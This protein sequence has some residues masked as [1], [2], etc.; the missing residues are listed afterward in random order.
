M[1]TVTVATRATPQDIESLVPIWQDANG[2]KYRVT[3]GL[4]AGAPRDAWIDDGV[5][6]PPPAPA[7]IAGIEGRTAL[8]MMGLIFVEEQTD[9]GG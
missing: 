8:A 3:S 6:P 4:V 1:I 5:I 7:V 2:V 9:E